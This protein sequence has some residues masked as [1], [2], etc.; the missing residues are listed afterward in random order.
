MDLTEYRR[1]C[2]EPSRFCRL[3][4]STLPTSTNVSPG[5]DNHMLDSVACANG[6]K[7]Q[8]CFSKWTPFEAD[9]PIPILVALILREGYDDEA[10]REISHS[11][12]Q[13]RKDNPLNLD[14][15]RRRFQFQN[16]YTVTLTLP[17]LDGNVH[18]HTHNAASSSSSGISCSVSFSTG[19][20]TRMHEA[21]LPS[22]AR[23]TP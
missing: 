6:K 4:L 14:R 9:T 11:L 8:Q 19:S 23:C 20:T 15:W 17:G 18:V 22:P 16:L 13:H 10:P 21:H 5:N 12:R 2:P 7:M 1:I 3:I